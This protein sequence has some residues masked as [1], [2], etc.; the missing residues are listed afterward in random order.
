MNTIPTV[1]PAPIY[2]LVVFAVIRASE[3]GVVEGAMFILGFCVEKPVVEDTFVVEVKLPTREVLVVED[4]L[5][6]ED[7]LDAED[8]LVVEDLLVMEDVLDAEDMLISEDVLEIEDVLDMEELGVPIILSP[9]PTVLARKILISSLIAQQLR[10]VGKAPQH[11]D[12]SS[13]HCVMALSAN[14]PPFYTAYEH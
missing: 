11:Q 3:V 1:T 9:V 8:M 13:S 10:A 6:M 5:V 14:E 7:V 2:I 4:V 12:P